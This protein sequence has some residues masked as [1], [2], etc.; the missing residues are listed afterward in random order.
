MHGPPQIAGKALY[1]R[2]SSSGDVTTM[3]H[4]SGTFALAGTNKSNGSYQTFGRQW[5][6]ARPLREIRSNGAQRRSLGT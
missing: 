2:L 1:S 3:M 5:R 6:N 4:G